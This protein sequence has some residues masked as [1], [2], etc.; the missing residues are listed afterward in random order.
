[1]R[2]SSIVITLGVVLFVTPVPGTFVGGGVVLLLG[3]VLR[4]LGH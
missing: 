2:L 4:L 1:M 3:V